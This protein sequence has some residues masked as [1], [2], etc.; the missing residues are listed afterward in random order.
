MLLMDRHVTVYKKR[1]IGQVRG[2]A[3]VR[4][5]G[6]GAIAHHW[7]KRRVS[8]ALGVGLGRSLAGI[9]QSVR[10]GEKAIQV[11]EATV[12]QVDDHNVLDP[13]GSPCLR[14]RRPR[15]LAYGGQQSQTQHPTNEMPSLSCFRFHPGSLEAA[16]SSA[17]AR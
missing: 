1:R 10:P 17:P 3:L 5:R 12:L 16:L 13:L 8:L 14:A 2:K 11:I 7:R 9:L 4:L 15:R 6:L